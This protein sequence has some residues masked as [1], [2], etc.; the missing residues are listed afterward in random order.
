MGICRGERLHNHC[1]V[2]TL[3]STLLY[4]SI[5]ARMHA[6]VRGGGGVL[7]TVCMCL[8]T[9]QPVGTYSTAEE[10]LYSTL[11]TMRLH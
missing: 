7:R 6:Y 4:H 9:R 1:T 5:H 3:L 8:G 2:G 11:Y 10:S